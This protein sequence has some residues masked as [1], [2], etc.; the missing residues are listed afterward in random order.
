MTDHERNAGQSRQ[1]NNGAS[2]AALRKKE[3]APE[4]EV[5]VLEAGPSTDVSS[6]AFTIVAVVTVILTLQYAQPVLIPIVI[7]IL[8]SYVLGP[9]VDSLARHGVSRWIGAVI[10]SSVS[11]NT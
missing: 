2:D 7:G 6:V 3:D 4:P 8:L 10:D 1:G 9:M 11:K 5:P